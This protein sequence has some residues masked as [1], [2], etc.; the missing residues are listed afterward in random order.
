MSTDDAI[1]GVNVD[2]LSAQ[3]SRCM[4]SLRLIMRKFQI[5]FLN[6]KK[7]ESDWGKLPGLIIGKIADHMIK[8]EPFYSV[9]SKLSVNKHWYEAVKRRAGRFTLEAKVKNTAAGM[10]SFFSFL[11]RFKEDDGLELLKNLKIEGVTEYLYAVS[12]SKRNPTV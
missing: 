8:T 7:T 4:V 5:L 11:G 1:D 3:L 10:E 12:Y 2:N 6:F 9:E